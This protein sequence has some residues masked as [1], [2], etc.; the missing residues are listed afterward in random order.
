MGT[1]RNP[2]DVVRGGVKSVRVHE[3][4]LVL[5]RSDQAKYP[6]WLG[7]DIPYEWSPST[8]S[9]GLRL[10]ASAEQVDDVGVRIDHGLDQRF[11]AG[12]EE[13]TGVSLLFESR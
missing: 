6:K 7:D 12:Y 9:F 4:S 5:S 3:R 8:R 13:A 11:G 10:R 2:G 1:N